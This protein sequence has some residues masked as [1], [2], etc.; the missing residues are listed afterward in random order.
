MR[1]AAR[2]LAAGPLAVLLLAGCTATGSGGGAPPD[3]GPGPVTEAAAETTVAPP[4]VT[5]KGSLAPAPPDGPTKVPAQGP[6]GRALPTN[7]W[8][9][10][11]LTGPG[12]Q[13]IW[14]HPV[15]VKAGTDGVQVSAAPPV[16]AANSV[17]TPFVPALT[18][19]GPVGVRVA[20]YGAFHVVLDAGTV[21]VTLV[22]GDPVV[23]LR[24]RGTPALTVAAGARLDGHRLQAAGQRWDLLGGTWRLDGTRL[25]GSDGRVALARVPDGVD[26]RAWQAATADAAAHPVVKTTARMSYDSAAGTVTQTLSAERAGGGPGVWAL[27]PHQKAGLLP[28]PRAVGGTFPDALG[29]LPLVRAD[30]VRV[31]VPMPGLLTAAPQVPL[32]PEARAAVVADLDRDL[33]APWP[34]RGRPRRRPTT[35]L[36]PHW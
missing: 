26:E 29:P 9:T 23:Y 35:P 34:R 30:S 2:R 11:A 6:Q 22:Q 16:A 17:V 27:L 14:A 32:P 33:A 1:A 7:Q 20:A 28:G 15:A 3:P 36:P 8:W 19:P 10:S 18:V 13:P 21:E 25:V 12:T 4:Q 24:F 31:R 5:G